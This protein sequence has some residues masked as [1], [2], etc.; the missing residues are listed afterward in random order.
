MKKI[1]FFM[2]LVVL[3]V[4]LTACGE[5]SSQLLPGGNKAMTI[6]D[7]AADGYSMSV[8]AGTFSD[9][10]EIKVEETEK[11]VFNEPEKYELLGTPLQISCDEY[12][13]VFFGTNV[14]LAMKLP[15]QAK[16]ESEELE[17][18]FVV[19]CDD[20]N[21]EIR[22]FEPDFIN[23]DDGTLTVSLPHFSW[24]STAK[25][26]PKEEIDLFLDSYAARRAVE[27]LGRTQAAS[28][29][30]PYLQAKIDALGLTAEAAQELKNAVIK[31]VTGSFFG[32]AGELGAAVYA[33]DEKDGYKTF[34]DEFD[35]K[36]TEALN[37]MLD[38]AGAEKATTFFT[39]IDKTSKIAGYLA[40]GDTESAMK[41]VGSLLEDEI[42]MGSV[43]TK[44]V[45][46]VGAK[47]NES[48]VNWKANEIEELYQIYKNGMEDIWHNEVIA[49]DWN[50]MST[51]LNTSSGF[52]KAKAVNRFYNLDK[53]GEVCKMYGWSF[54]TYE[55]MPDK[56]KDEFNRRA[57]EGLKK[58]FEERL[59]QEAAAEQ[60]KEKERIC[61]Q[62]ML[63]I[64]GA[65]RSGMYMEFF[66]EKSRGDYSLTDRLNR[67]MQVRGFISRFVNEAALEKTT[68]NGG[69]NYGSLLNEWVRLYNDNLNDRE[70]VIR[71]FTKFLK[72]A[73]LLNPMYKPTPAING[74]DAFMGEWYNAEGK[75]T[76]LSRNGDTVI[77]KNPDLEWYDGDVCCT[78]YSA[79]FD[80]TASALKLSGITTWVSSPGSD[81][82]HLELD[83]A[84]SGRTYTA[85]EVS[86]GMVTGM[87][88]VINTYTR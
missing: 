66:G 49:G 35:S 19:G 76:I 39:G 53:V 83:A 85:T 24:W 23:T 22:Y 17:R 6:G 52:T 40:G 68:K 14:V 46:Y 71:E 5:E 15:E 73:N 86:D 28:E 37:E 88:D 84:G 47:V 54:K 82:R 41:E 38:G 61:I 45:G 77:E 29:L 74:I 63:G 58:Y 70:I 2:I 48:M 8:P 62:D 26:T 42:P 56:Y 44:A 12:D 4:S 31:E 30:E 16:N 34:Q 25:L 65:L 43:I 64:T 3:A 51:Y 87:K 60:I 79:E 55:E 10:A 20:Q 75:R 69:H 33:S 7:T 72:D 57:E 32:D 50:S 67:L 9:K 27:K 21:G 36:I 1:L 13:G 59:S 81:E 78:E 11:S 18:Y 80:E